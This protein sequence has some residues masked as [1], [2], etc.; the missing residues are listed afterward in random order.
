VPLLLL[1]PFGCFVYCRT[2]K[3]ETLTSIS[4]VLL[5][6]T[7]LQSEGEWIKSLFDLPG[8]KG[9]VTEGPDVVNITLWSVPSSKFFSNLSQ[10]T[11]KSMR[12]DRGNMKMLAEVGVESSLIQDTE[13]W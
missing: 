11:Q 9:S 2:D 13:P 1:P 3:P 7:K 8:D 10:G 12:I 6:L 5:A 4:T